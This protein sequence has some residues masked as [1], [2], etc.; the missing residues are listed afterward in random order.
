[1]TVVF[2][3]KVIL[4]QFFLI[5]A[6]EASGASYTDTV[7]VRNI[8]QE[9]RT[10]I[11]GVHGHWRSIMKLPLITNFFTL[12]PNIYADSICNCGCKNK[13]PLNCWDIDNMVWNTNQSRKQIPKQ[14]NDQRYIHLKWGQLS[15]ITNLQ[16]KWSAS[17]KVKNM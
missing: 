11:I 4:H 9:T 13:L 3:K 1:M 14:L 12:N 7:F 5:H 2:T 8:I 17:N 15:V 10:H 16:V 6:T